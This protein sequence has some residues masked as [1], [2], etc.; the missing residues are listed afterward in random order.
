MLRT[1]T[2]CA[3][4][5]L[6]HVV[7]MRSAN[8]APTEPA[9]CTPTAGI[10]C[11]VIDGVY[12]FKIDVYSPR[13]TFETV[14]AHDQTSGDAPFTPELVA[15]MVLRAPYA[16]RNPLLAINTDYWGFPHG[17]EGLTVKNGVRIPNAGRNNN[18]EYRRSSFSIAG[19]RQLR[20][21]RQSD[22]TDPA[23]FGCS[24]WKPDPN[25]YFTTMGG[26]PL[27][28]T[29]GK[30][31][32]SFAGDVAPCDAE[33][34]DRRFCT[35]S[36]AWS[37]VAMTRDRRTLIVAATPESNGKTMWRMA[38]ILLAAGAWTAMKL[39]GGG[40]TQLWYRESGVLIP[41]NR[42]IADALLVFANDEC[43][44]FCDVAL[45]SKF[46]REIAFLKAA[47]IVFGFS[48][49]LYHPERSITRAQ[50]ASI[51]WRWIAWEQQPQVCTTAFPDLPATETPHYDAI[52]YL[53]CIGVIKG[54]SDGT[55]RPEEP[56]TRAQAVTLVMRLL[57]QL[58]PDK[59]ILSAPVGDGYS[60]PDVTG[61]PHRTD[62]ERARSIRLVGGYS[63]G[64]FRP[65]DPVD[66]GQ[67]AKI[68][69]R[70]IY[71][72]FIDADVLPEVI[73]DYSPA[74]PDGTRMTRKGRMDTDQNGQAAISSAS[75]ALFFCFPAAAGAQIPGLTVAA[76]NTPVCY[77][78]ADGASVV[79]RDVPP[80][81][82]SQ[83]NIQALY[84][85]GVTTGCSS[86]DPSIFCPD[87]DTTRLQTIVFL[88]RARH[89]RTTGEAGTNFAPPTA[90]SQIFD[91]MP[92]SHPWVDWANYAYDLGITQGSPNCGAG[93]NFCPDLPVTRLEM[94]LFTLRARYGS[95][96]IAGLPA[97]LGIFEDVPV[98]D[99]HAR[100]MEELYWQGFTN[101]SPDC[102]SGFRYCPADRVS[103][104]HAAAFVVRAFILPAP[105]TPRQGD[106]CFSTN[107]G[108][109]IP[110][111][112]GYVLHQ[113]DD[114]DVACYHRAVNR[115]KM[116]FNGSVTGIADVDMDG[117]SI[118]DSGELYFS[119]STA[120]TIPGV[121]SVHDEDV[122]VFR[123]GSFQLMVD[124][125]AMPGL[126]SED[127]DALHWE[128]ASRVYL[129]T[130]SGA[131]LPWDAEDE[132]VVALNPVAR[133]FD[134]FFDGS[135]VGLTGDVDAVSVAAS[136]PSASTLYL[137]L[138]ASEC[139]PT[140]AGSL[141]AEPGDVV[142]Y[143]GSTGSAT[144]GAFRPVLCFDASQH[145]GLE[146][147]NID[148][149]HVKAGLGCDPIAPLPRLSA[150]LRLSQTAL[151]FTDEFARGQP[152][153]QAFSISNIGGDE[154]S[155]SI[156]EEIDW[157][158]VSSR[159]GSGDGTVTV[160]INSAGMTLGTHLAVLQVDAG[161]A[162]DGRQTVQVSLSIAGEQVFVP[163]VMR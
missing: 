63:D 80:G 45:D 85:A 162:Q 51:L 94:A 61:G 141:C 155:W 59:A 56:V 129:S 20:M 89:Y 67:F 50:T 105:A 47:G 121:G 25:R 71:Y 158:D 23:D 4:I 75:S 90:T 17:P 55:F 5:L 120:E 13:Y 33:S 10:D 42:A 146:Q 16:D 18:D 101:G 81:H 79:I 76:D 154:L 87:A 149:L 74:L 135:A 107:T 3:A 64:N 66:R 28:I 60:F 46:R 134:P 98:T 77:R 103:R 132:D 29:Q 160:S 14:I 148:G 11:Q 12:I 22:C 144:A 1:L 106:I 112:G 111:P 124:G 93:T 54:F 95:G 97:P 6:C 109:D 145:P 143:D 53:S 104:A 163:R 159:S 65:D 69:A 7:L 2:V 27:F 31:L 137:S 36:R 30:R 88:L 113:V 15:E 116:Y 26:G 96:Y 123:N 92:L 110:R 156:S 57:T 140:P 108:Y 99:N 8:A 147:V 83:A 72:A 21:G 151:H 73:D 100:A 114:E 40:S 128:S 44:P 130:L 35:D 119:T 58:R 84:N 125:A 38:D 142:R 118:G 86:A 48:D 139:L 78:R 43:E 37:A 152:A 70:A 157:L 91:D 117:L 49:G 41:S 82:W 138:N 131:D 62:I 39:D 136:A 9:A 115:F 127:V 52:V 133:D 102:G 122:L 34:I 126:G 24:A 153:P 19:D 32:Q 150:I 68:V 161:E